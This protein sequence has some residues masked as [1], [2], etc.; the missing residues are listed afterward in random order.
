MKDGT[1]FA[2][3]MDYENEDFFKAH[4][5]I[6]FDTP[7]ALQEYEIIAA[8]RTQVYKKNDKV[9]KHYNFINA[10]NAAEFEN[11]IT[12][13]KNLAC[14][15]TGV[16]AKYGDKLITLCTCAYHVKNGQFVV[17]ARKIK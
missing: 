15:D 9:F 12:N 8:F 3:L 11:Y 6:H 1:M 2:G 5:V 10:K 4:P 14:Y 16:T 7:D 17:V 13:I